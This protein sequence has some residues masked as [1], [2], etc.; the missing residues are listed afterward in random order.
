MLSVKIMEKTE[1]V[2]VIL[3]E[4]LLEYM[5]KHNYNNK[6]DVYS[7][8]R[9]VQDQLYSFQDQMDFKILNR[10][11]YSIAQFEANID[12]LKSSLHHETRF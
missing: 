3:D 1:Y 12:L 6:Q 2:R 9:A 5:T 8:V 7:L 10:K 4:I 11:S